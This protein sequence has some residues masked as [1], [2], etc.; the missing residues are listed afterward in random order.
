MTVTD[1]QAS[2]IRNGRRLSDLALPNTTT[3]LVTEAGDFM[4]LYRQEG[5]DAV[6]DA[7]FI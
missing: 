7:V 1:A 6:A 5:A 2:Y 4:A 3:A